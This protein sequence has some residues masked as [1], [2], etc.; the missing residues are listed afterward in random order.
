MQPLVQRVLQRELLQAADQLAGP[1]GGERQLGVILGRAQPQ[2]GE[3]RDG[4]VGERGLGQAGQRGAAP[5]G[6]RAGEPAGR[7]VGVP[8]VPAGPALRGQ[9]LELRDVGGPGRRRE[10]VAGRQRLNPGRVVRREGAAQPRDQR[11][12]RVAGARRRLVAPD[13]VDQ[14]PGGDQAALVQGQAGQQGAQPQA[15]DLDGLAG[16]VAG[17]EGTEQPDPHPTSLMRCGY[18][19]SAL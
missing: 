7:G 6:Q 17:L 13:R 5:Q 19:N 15:G 3:A 12:Q 18:L 16:V 4:G 1:A 2:F 8:G 9:P 14:R 11:V 10:P